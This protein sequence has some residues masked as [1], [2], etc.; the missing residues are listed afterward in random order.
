MMAVAI[1]RGVMRSN[2]MIVLRVHSEGEIWL[3]LKSNCPFTFNVQGIFIKQLSLTLLGNKEKILNWLF[4]LPSHAY[5]GTE[6]SGA[7]CYQSASGNTLVC[8]LPTV[9]CGSTSRRLRH[10]YS[11]PG[12]RSSEREHKNPR[13]E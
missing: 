12:I 4:Y 10:K 7:Y 5:P 6:I 1:R 8:W 13:G 9:R 2:C 3:L 11:S